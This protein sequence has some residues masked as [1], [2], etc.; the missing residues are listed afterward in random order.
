VRFAR[1]PP[2]GA[3]RP[4][5]LDAAGIAC[6]LGDIDGAFPSV[7]R[8]DQVRVALEQGVL[9]PAAVDGRRYGPRSPGRARSAGR[10][11]RWLFLQASNALVGPDDEVLIPGEARRPTTR[12]SSGWCRAAGA[13]RAGVRGQR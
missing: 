5:V 10:P 9:P 8:M 3:E 12:S 7:D 2:A 4:V 13:D 1:V 6:E 11:S